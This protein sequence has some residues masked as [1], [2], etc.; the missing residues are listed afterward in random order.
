[1][2]THITCADILHP[3][4]STGLLFCAKMQDAFAALT[5][6]SASKA[7]NE[8]LKV[9]TKDFLKIIEAAQKG[10]QW[11]WCWPYVPPRTAAGRRLHKNCGNLS[12]LSGQQ[13]VDCETVNSACQGAWFIAT[14]N[15]QP[16]SE[17][18]LVGC[19]TVNSGSLTTASLSQST[20]HTYVTAPACQLLGLCGQIFQ[21]TRG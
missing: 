18:Q 14:G 20:T 16:L 21:E 17:Q 2:Q 10:T 13:L 4:V 19:D 9:C 8:L 15:L 3:L 5:M 11:R 6:F 1:M 12:P 7:A